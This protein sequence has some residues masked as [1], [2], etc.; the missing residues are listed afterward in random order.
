MR[1]TSKLTRLRAPLATCSAMA[2]AAL[3]AGGGAAR[4]QESNAMRAGVSARVLGLDS[5]KAKLYAPIASLVVPG[6]GQLALGDNRF[7]GYAAAEIVGWFLYAKDRQDQ[8]R[9]E[10]AYKDLARQVARAHFS[11]AFPD[12]PWA[13]YE[14][15]R[16]WQESG[17]YSQSG[18]TLEP[19][20]DTLTYNGYKWQLALRTTAT[21]DDALAQY[22]QVAV[23]PEFQWSWQNAREQWTL[24]KNTTGDR[25]DANRAAIR[26]L[27]LIA[28]NH[29]L[30]MIDAFATF[31][32]SVQPASNGV[33]GADGLRIGASLRW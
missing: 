28:A 11:S 19:E 9:Q 23:K 16:D 29:I 1:T 6:A 26:M 12:A 14:Q 30:S 3:V 15:L 33:G 27:S 17:V 4:A 10:S 18:T 7:V 24:Y 22:R 8:A 13:Y 25:N 5:S 21:R 20:T 2:L 32:L 31:R